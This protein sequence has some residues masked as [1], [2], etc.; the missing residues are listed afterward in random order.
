[1]VV[2]SAARAIPAKTSHQ[3]PLLPHRV[4]PLSVP[5]LLNEADG[6]TCDD[7]DDA[8]G[9]RADQDLKR[10][11]QRGKQGR[12][13]PHKGALRVQQLQQLGNKVPEEA[14]GQRPHEEVLT[15]HRPS[16]A[17]KS[18]IPFWGRALVST[19]TEASIISSPY[20]MSAIITP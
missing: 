6:H 13:E 10:V 20:P 1:M 8:Q 16:R 18:C 3:V 19:T 7:L 5:D 2:P 11:V 14:A 12:P 17:K 15:P 9:H 4:H